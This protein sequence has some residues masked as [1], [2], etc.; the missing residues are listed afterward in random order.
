[1]LY[2]IYRVVDKVSV[3]S[4]FVNDYWI[5]EVISKVPGD[6][7]RFGHPLRFS[8]PYKEVSQA[9]SKSICS[10]LLLLD[11]FHKNEPLLKK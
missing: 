11:A 7:N 2:S 1:M 8:T 9:A 5:M 4:R 10:I 6:T 3:I